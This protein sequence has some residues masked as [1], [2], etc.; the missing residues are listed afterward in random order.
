[1]TRAWRRL[2]AILAFALLI[3]Q[4]AIPW[5]VNHF[6][7][8]DGPSHLYTGVVLKELLLHRTTPYA[9]FYRLQSKIV[10]NWA[11]GV[12]LGTAASLVGA[13]HAEQLLVSLSVIA[14]FFAFAYACAAIYPGASPWNPIANFLLQ[15]W[16]L[17]VGF[18]NFYLGMALF[19]FVIGFY[20]RHLDR[21]TL[22]RATLLAVALLGLFFT[23]IM[24]AAVAA[25]TLVM[26]GLWVHLGGRRLSMETIWTAAARLGILAVALIPL[27]VFAILFAKS[28]GE[29]V[30][31]L[32]EAGSAFERFPMDLFVTGPERSG[33]Q[34]LLWPAVLLVMGMSAL[35]MRRLE[36]RTARG[37]LLVAAV[38]T[39]GLYL[40]APDNGFGGQDVKK[41]LAWA[42]FILGCLLA[43]SVARLRPLRTPLSIYISCFLAATLITSA[44]VGKA[45]SNAADAYISATDHIPPGA[46]FV[47]LF[48]PVSGVATRFG[49]EGVPL[50]PLF[51]FDAHIAATRHCIDLSD[52]QAASGLFPVIYTPIIDTRQ[53]DALWGFEYAPNNNSAI[54]PWLRSA[55]RRPIGYVVVVGD[56]TS[57]EAKNTDMAATLAGLES[58]MRLVATANPGSFVR[59]YQRIAAR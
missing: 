7:T 26:V 2:P 8:Q 38:L 1:M 5:T 14:G 40:F 42:F 58:G 37:G 24:A 4:T 35:S 59:V 32:P 47:R 51:H 17:S 12:L 27:L 54:L 16:F 53:R 30:V 13:D 23:H 56:E 3:F 45:M 48:Y 22:R 52:Y 6:V 33:R 57:V 28:A 31:F 29:S 55:L 49:F 39:G 10:P 50:A 36:W 21:M 41:R 18:Y 44:R 46:T 43:C 25:L 15:N 34:D 19:P 20:I 11:A 9:S